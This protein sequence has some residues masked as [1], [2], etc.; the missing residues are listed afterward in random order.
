MMFTFVKMFLNDVHVRKPFV[1][2]F[3][4]VK[5]NVHV[6]NDEPKMLFTNDVKVVNRSLMM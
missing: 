2:M 3:T 1:R 6:R 4:F 5:M